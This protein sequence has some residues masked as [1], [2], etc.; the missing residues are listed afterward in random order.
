MHL[1]Q[2]LC[3]WLTD[4]QGTMRLLEIL[5]FTKHDF[6][7]HWRSKSTRFYLKTGITSRLL[8]YFQQQLRWP[9]MSV[10]VCSSALYLVNTVLL[11][12][13]CLTLTDFKRVSVYSVD[14]DSSQLHLFINKTVSRL[15]ELNWED[16]IWFLFSWAEKTNF[17]VSTKRF[18][19]FKQ[20]LSTDFSQY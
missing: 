9:R 14:N 7:S 1:L 6:Q 18:G 3:D 4:S 5:L 2:F 16:S 8:A 11:G 19:E 17:V 20:R 12:L 15:L 10:S 13:S